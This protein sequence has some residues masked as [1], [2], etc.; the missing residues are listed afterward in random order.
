MTAHALTGGNGRLAALGYRYGLLV[1]LAAVTVVFSLGR[2]AFATYD[3]L[4]IVLQSVSIVGIVA[5]GVTVSMAAG[6]FDLSVGA[7]V[8]FTVMVTAFAMV[9]LNLTGA[10]AVGFGLAAGLLVAAVN[11]LLV[12]VARI[13][14]LIATLGTMFLFQGLA[15]ILTSG[16]SIAPGMA[17]GDGTAPGRFTEGFGRLGTGRVLSVPVPVLVLVLLAGAG[18]ILLVHTRWGRALYAIGGNA[19]A[20]RLAGI[21]VARHRA[22]AYAVSGLCAAVAGILLTARLGRGDVGAGDAYLLQS[23]AAA[24]VGFAV[25]GANR[26]NILGTAVGALF[27]GVV[28]NGLTML[29]A[30]YYAQTFVQGALLVVSLVISFTLSPGRRR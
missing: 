30:P 4:L 3:N 17:V 19:E 16:Q 11:V 21:R 7:N 20:A 14:D 24:L 18:H 15:L 23:V 28:V 29:D 8:G 10:T 2:P 5:F 22:L 12:V 1:V 26:P 9:R 27:I 13:P 6:G 25:L